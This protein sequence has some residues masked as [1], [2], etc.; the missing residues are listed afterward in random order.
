MQTVRKVLIS[1]LLALVL[2]GVL[3]L[4]SGVGSFLNRG[5][6]GF[7]YFGG[8]RNESDPNYDAW[9]WSRHVLSTAY[10]ALPT[11]LLVVS[12]SPF[13]NRTKTANKAQLYKANI[14]SCYDVFVAAPWTSL[15]SSI[16]S[17]S[18]DVAQP[19]C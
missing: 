4:T 10:F 12:L 1:V 15:A 18:N 7:I 9:Y 5:R 19:L 2:V 11:G 6:G 3:T 8:P 17:C 14:D 16:P 13:I